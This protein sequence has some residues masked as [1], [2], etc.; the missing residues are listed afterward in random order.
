MGLFHEYDIRGIYPTELTED[1]SYRLGKA[2]AQHT[3]AKNVVIGYDSRNGNLKLFSALAKSLT[4]QGVNV[5]HAG[6]ISRPMLN[7]VA[8]H[9][10]F[11]LGII[12]T[13]SHN[14]KEYNGFKFILHGRVLCYDNG[15]NKIEGLLSD[16]NFKPKRSKKKGKIISKDYIDDYVGFLSSYLSTEFKRYNRKENIKVIC[17]ASNGAA[18]EIIKRFMQRSNIGNELLF[19]DPDGTFYCHNPNPLDD[20][21]CVVLSKKVVE[22][23][24]DFG[25]IV[26]PDADRIRFIDE[27]GRIVENNYMD[28]IVVKDILKKNRKAVIVHDVVAR[29]VLSETIRKY[30]GKNIVS[31]VGISNIERNM[32]EN[33]ALFGCEASGHRYYKVMNSLDSGLMTLVFVLNSLYNKEHQGKRLSKLC[34]KYDRYFDI[35]EHNYRV[36]DD[37]KKDIILKNIYEHYK[38]EKKK[39]KVKHE[40]LI[41]GVSVITKRY[42]LTIR[43]SNTESIIRLRIESKDRKI[44]EKVQKHIEKFI[45]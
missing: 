43:K 2:V 11:D 12:I 22:T 17:D 39:L 13:A 30:G 7:W 21:A 24:A 23:K 26:D 8:W 31:Q 36:D 25:F 27:K 33:K 28:C 4:E 10:K 20:S 41:D 1:F 3:K 42:W 14:P 19:A 44:L 9:H 18:G 45:K 40:Y 29:K 5:V 34:S 32:I 35:G 15:L 38:K 16:K 6:L 37:A